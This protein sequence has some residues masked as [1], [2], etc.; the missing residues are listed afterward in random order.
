MLGFKRLKTVYLIF[1]EVYRRFDDQEMEDINNKNKAIHKKLIDDLCT[2]YF[3]ASRKVVGNFTKWKIY[4]ADYCP[5]PTDDNETVF[6]DICAL[7]REKLIG[8]GDYSVLLDIFGKIDESAVSL[9]NRASDSI[10]QNNEMEAENQREPN[11]EASSLIATNPCTAKIRVRALNRDKEMHNDIAEILN[12]FVNH[13]ESVL[14]S[15]INPSSRKNVESLLERFVKKN[16]QSKTLSTCIREESF[17]LF[18]AMKTCHGVES[19]H[20]YSDDGCVVISV[21]FGEKEDKKRARNDVEYSLENKVKYAFK[22]IFTVA[23]LKRP[24]ITVRIT[25]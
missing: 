10:R 3:G 25:Y 19:C 22:M 23:S 18:R 1:A 4:Y 9:I 5:L 16:E 21:E 20:I 17:G 13:P 7:Q 6:E 11:N 2:G 15:P 14:S 24:D 8:V 12:E